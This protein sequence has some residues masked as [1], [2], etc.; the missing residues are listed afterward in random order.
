[1]QDSC[2]KSLVISKMKTNKQL[3]VTLSLFALMALGCQGAFGPIGNTTVPAPGTTNG[4]TV[5]YQQQQDRIG[6][7][8]TTPQQVTGAD[9]WSPRARDSIRVA[10]E[11]TIQPMSYQQDVSNTHSSS[12]SGNSNGVIRIPVRLGTD[13]TTGTVT[14]LESTISP[15]AVIQNNSDD[16]AWTSREQSD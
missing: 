5:Y 7:T 11:P 6:S 2:H 1:M 8:A 16:E 15:E 3:S 14:E 12:E 4:E 13:N 9:S 10:T